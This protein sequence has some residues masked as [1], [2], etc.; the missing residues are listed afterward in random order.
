[1]SGS[2]PNVG[3]ASRLPPSAKP[4]AALSTARADAL[5]GQAGR[6]PYFTVHGEVRVR[7]AL[8]P[9]TA[10]LSASCGLL[11]DKSARDHRASRAE[12]EWY[13]F[14]AGFFSTRVR[15]FDHRISTESTCVTGPSPK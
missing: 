15:P 2:R 10:Q 13:W 3:Q 11:C 9:K 6:L 8:Y 14:I 12:T 4:T 7:V 1:M 5:A